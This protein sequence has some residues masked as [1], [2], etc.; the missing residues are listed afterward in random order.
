VLRTPDPDDGRRAQLTVTVRGQSLMRDGEAV[1]NE[2]RAEWES[3]VGTDRIA[4]VQDALQRLLGSE[5]PGRN[6][7]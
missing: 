7:E 5:S 2:L 1:F 4:D 3:L 6:W